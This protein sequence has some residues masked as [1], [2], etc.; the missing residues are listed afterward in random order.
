MR[1]GDSDKRV[2]KELQSA[3]NPSFLPIRTAQDWARFRGAPKPVLQF[4]VALAKIQC[5]CALKLP[6]LSDFAP[7]LAELG[8]QVVSDF[9]ARILPT[10]PQLQKLFDFLQ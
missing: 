6:K 2:S 1:V 10:F 9:P 7:N 3:P 5:Q 4:T 8:A